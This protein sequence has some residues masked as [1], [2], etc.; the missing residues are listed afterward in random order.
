MRYLTLLLLCGCS[1]APTPVVVPEQPNKNRD[2]YVDRLEHEASEGAAAIIV[3]KK[4]VEGKGK[5]LLDLTETRLSGI[6][7]PTSEQVSKYETT[8]ASSKALKAEQTKAKEV[9][10][11]TT[12]LYEKVAKADKEN[13]DLRN[14]I[15]AMEREKAWDKV[16]DKFLLMAMVFGFAGAAFMVANTFIG[17]G[18]KAGVVMF[19]LSGVCAAT[20]FILRDVVESWWFKWAFG[21]CVVIGMAYGMY[22]G[23]HTH[24]EVK[25]RLRSSDTPQA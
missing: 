23:L 11:E 14:S 21:A 24:K 13:E 4:N 5:P 15:A 9:D 16:A 8:L 10:A 20:P 12:K 17:K 3:A 6:K 2:E 25:C 19:L 1:H 22:A 7:K 18:L